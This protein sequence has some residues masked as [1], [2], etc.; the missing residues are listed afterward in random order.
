MSSQSQTGRHITSR[1]LDQWRIC[2]T[3]RHVISSGNYRFYHKRIQPLPIK[4]I[5]KIYIELAYGEYCQIYEFMWNQYIYMITMILQ[6]RHV[7]ATVGGLLLTCCLWT[8]VR[9]LARERSTL[10][11]FNLRLVQQLETPA[12]AGCRRGCQRTPPACRW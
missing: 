5:Y 8:Y 11:V 4:K 3:L 9:V 12:K 10:K 6:D 2:R 7:F 1:R